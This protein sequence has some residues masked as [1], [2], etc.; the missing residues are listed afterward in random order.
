MKNKTA[1]IGL[2]GGLLIGA[3]VAGGLW[4]VAY[5]TSSET[6]ASDTD[7]AGSPIARETSVPNG[8]SKGEPNTDRRVL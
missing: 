6:H 8:D 7:R 4:F 1:I 3:A 2:A 5:R